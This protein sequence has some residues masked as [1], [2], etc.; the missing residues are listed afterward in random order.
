MKYAMSKQGVFKTMQGEG[1]MAG[2]PCVFVRLAGCSVGCPECDT[3]YSAAGEMD[4][5]EIAREVAGLS[6][7]S[8]VFVTGGEPTDQ[9]LTPL[10]RRLRSVGF[11]VALNTSGVRPVQLGAWY[12]GFDFVSVSP[13]RLDDSWVQR[14]GDQV[15]LVPG[16]NG[17]SLDSADP[18]AFARFNHRYVT[19]MS[20]SMV[21]E[22][23]AWVEANVG[24]R[25]GFQAH[26]TW[27]IQ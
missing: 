11:R 27:G 13:H 8:W 7:S 6:G 9:D 10:V 3:D 24:W 12:D 2:E 14:S 18:K 4:E 26:K 25:L 19:P 23:V 22:C 20:R 21:P 5:N 16:L 17:L 15:N 1:A